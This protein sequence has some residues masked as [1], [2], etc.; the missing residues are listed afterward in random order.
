[1]IPKPRFEALPWL[2][3]QG[4]VT[5][6]GW[7]NR[8]RRYGDE[9]KKWIKFLG[10]S[11]NWSDFE[12][13]AWQR[14][15]LL[16][17]IKLARTGTIHYARSLPLVEDLE[18]SK[19]LEEILL[20]LPV[21]E[22]QSLR[23]HAHDFRNSE[24][25]ETVVTSTSGSTGSPM[26]V[27]HDILSLQRRFAFLYD[28]LRMAGIE[29][30]EPSVRLSGRI[31]CD[32][33]KSQNKPW[34]YNSA[35]RQLFLSSYHL[36]PAHS[37]V[38]SEK[39]NSL[40]PVLI[41]GYPSGII[42]VLRLLESSKSQ[43]TSLKAIITT[44]E[45]LHPDLRAK[46]SKLSGV[47]V[48]DYYSASEGV[49]IIQQCP[50]GT[51]HVRWQSGIFE[52]D[53][54]KS[55]DFEGDGELICTSFVQD[56]TPLIRYRTGDTVSGL[57]QNI[58][59]T[60]DCGL[61]TPTVVQIHGRLEDTVRTSDNRSLGMFTYRTLKDI[62]GLRETQVIQKDYADFEV[63]CVVA[64]G[65]DPSKTRKKI[66]EAFERTLGYSIHLHFNNVE[67]IPRGPNGKIRL[68]I[69]KIPTN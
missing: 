7:K 62:E 48:M 47:P 59:V 37:A 17:L 49:P 65:A 50:F 23:N 64:P 19:T 12:R 55:I 1:M 63:N 52:V 51:Y 3:R 20:R 31:F 32:V 45:T 25:A 43:L 68:V 54:G 36:S 39:L 33:G 42:E 41:D 24:I 11:N 6:L 61:K 53:D 16:S 60:C 46:I 35:E 28:H 14:S 21:L 58:N 38:I 5:T 2:V 34:L 56:R 67:K 4:A 10:Q 57:Q 22:K 8:R 69:S 40:A 15:T 13:L 44:A 30:T 66:K 26:K 27:G 18:K 9:Y 29:I